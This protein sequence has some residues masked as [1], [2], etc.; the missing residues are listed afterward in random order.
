MKLKRYF[1]FLLSWALVSVT[2]LMYAQNPRADGYKGLWSRTG[3][4]LEFGYKYSGGLG[5]FSSQHVPLAIYSE[6]ADKTF[7]VYCGTSTPEESHLQIMISYYDHRTNRVPKPVIVYD[8]MGVSDPQD[9]ATISIDSGGYIYVFVSGRARTRPGII[10]RSS[11]PWSIDSFDQVFKGEIVFPQPWWL[12]DSCFILMHTEVRRGREIYWSTGVDGQHWSPIS[13]LAGMGGHHQ[14][15]NVYGNTLFSAFSYLPGGSPDGR[16][17][18][19]LVKT[20][21]YGKTWKTVEGHVLSTPVTDIHSGSLVKDYQAENRIVYIKDLNF[22]SS[23]NPVILVIISSGSRPGPSGDPRELMV[24]RW[25]DGKWNFV[26][27]CD[28][29]HNHDMG[30]IFTEDDEWRIIYPTEPGPQK[31]GAGGEIALWTSRDEGETWTKSSMLTSGSK[32]N[33]SYVRRPVSANREFYCFWVD[34]DPEK[35]S[36]SHI[37]FTNKDC[38]KVWVLPYS[39]EKDYARP[40]R[41]K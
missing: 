19:Y 20:E 24:V 32:Y 11:K 26:K 37:Y 23:G 3:P 10:F 40:E 14:V 13:K 22:D 34:G 6:V 12:N 41:I 5:T 28:I 15:T 27:V 31:D 39:M 21:N 7:F 8:K 36:E 35:I 4:K 38:D 2:T 30:S 17:N 16:T 33:N 1:T 18:L 9:N 29:H 25:K